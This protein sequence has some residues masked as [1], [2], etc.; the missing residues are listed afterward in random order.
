MHRSSRLLLT[1]RCSNLVT[2]LALVAALVVALEGC[3][4]AV[5]SSSRYAADVAPPPLFTS[6][7]TGPVQLVGFGGNVLD[8]YGT[9]P[10][11]ELSIQLSDM[12]KRALFGRLQ[13]RHVKI[14]SAVLTEPRLGTR[15]EM[16]G[17]SVLGVSVN[18]SAP[19]NRPEVFVH[20]AV[21]RFTVTATPR[22][23]PTP[24]RY[25]RRPPRVRCRRPA[26]FRASCRFSP[27][28]TSS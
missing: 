13:L 11:T 7:E 22:P 26:T 28:P 12:S 24:H 10:P 18:R 20:L 8:P 15:F 1:H 4:A 16:H 25:R 3:S 21:A 23:A 14:A 5:T 19:R 9:P 2:V 27:R 17:V 6:R